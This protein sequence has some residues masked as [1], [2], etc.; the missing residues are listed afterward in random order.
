[1]K[2]KD[3]RQA[4][5]R[6]VFFQIGVPRS[7][8]CPMSVYL[9]EFACRVRDSV[10]SPKTVK[11]PPAAKVAG[12]PIRSQRN[13]AIRLAN[14]SAMPLAKLKKPNAVARRCGGF[15]SSLSPQLCAR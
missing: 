3:L 11:A 10:S 6:K 13:P 2:G 9:M 4:K 1:M 15:T 5:Q 12:G 8:V 7:T 14:N